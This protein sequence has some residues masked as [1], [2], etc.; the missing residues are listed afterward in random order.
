LQGVVYVI[1]VK[2]YYTIK[3]FPIPGGPNLKARG[4]LRFRLSR[5]SLVI[6]FR[7]LA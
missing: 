3:Q 4:P 5:K 1:Y 6:L 7:S 2:M